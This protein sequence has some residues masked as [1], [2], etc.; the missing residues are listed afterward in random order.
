V[1]A[2]AR[3]RLTI[4]FDLRADPIAGVV[5]GDGDGDGQPFAGWM[6][7]TRAIETALDA[8]RQAD[9]PGSGRPAP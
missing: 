6:D 1:P 2:S 3:A 9:D 4:E 7:L 8:A 5:H